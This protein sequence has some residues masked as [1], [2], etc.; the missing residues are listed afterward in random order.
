MPEK[1]HIEGCSDAFNC[2]CYLC[3]GAQ[4]SDCYKCDRST[5]PNYS[6]R[7]CKIITHEQ[8]LK[9]EYEAIKH[10]WFSERR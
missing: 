1:I 7:T 6:K 5:C 10:V 9:R 2:K 3:G 4:N 8:Y